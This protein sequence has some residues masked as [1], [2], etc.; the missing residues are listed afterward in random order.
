MALRTLSQL[1]T[2][3]LGLLIAAAVVPASLLGVALRENRRAVTQFGDVNRSGSLRARSLQLYAL[4]SRNQDSRAALVDM[5]AVRESLR[6]RYPEEVARTDTAWA[7][8]AA[9]ESRTGRVDW[10]AAE[11]MRR[12]ADTQTRAIEVQ[13]RQGSAA[14]SRLLRAGLI[15]MVGSL[16]A[17]L[18]LLAGLARAETRRRRLQTTLEDSQALFLAA[19]Q[20]MRDGFAVQDQNGV[21]LMC[22]DGADRLL[23]LAP[24]ELA[25]TPLTSHGWRFCREDGTDFPREEHPTRRALATG[26]VQPEQVV[27]LLRDG[28]PVQWLAICAAPLRHPG[29][30]QPYA[31]VQ[32]FADVTDRKA[33]EI[34][35]RQ[36]EERMRRLHE[37]SMTRDLTVAGRME[38]LLRL[39]CELFNLPAGMLSRAVEDRFEALY[40]VSG[41]NLPAAGDVCGMKDT[42]CAQVLHAERPLARE[43]IGETDWREIPIYAAF[44]LESYIGAPLWV[45]GRAYGTLCFYSTQ[46]RAVP[47]TEADLEFVRLMAQWAGGELTREESREQIESYSIVLEFQ[48][49]ELEKANAELESLAT[50]DGL[51][52]IKNRRAF[53]TRLEEEVA[54]ATRYSLPLSLLL[55][56]VDQFKSYN[57]TF[58]HPAGDEVLKTVAQL[59]D[60]SARETDM[61]ARYGG[62]EFAVLLP[63]TDAAGAW[64]IAERIRQAIARQAWPHRSIT[65]SVGVAHL[66][67]VVDTGSQLIARA[68]E[69]LYQSKA[70]GRNRVSAASGPDYSSPDYSDPDYR[71]MAGSGV[72]SGSLI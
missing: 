72:R 13:A 36:A 5:A 6:R 54:R 37:L 59:L 69:A 52:G 12:A 2:G 67:P 40:A 18:L 17:T 41:E 50:R 22:S 3:F 9:Q 33:A 7:V 14:A 64:V 63:Q 62:E 56:D 39:G 27:G 34:A 20:A 11:A 10:N 26:E 28:E 24:G 25:G 44:G 19:M 16:A 32:T 51:T 30:E 49:Q 1:N 23:H 15:G 29:E 42:Y 53:G 35:V 48:M 66:L 57:D 4:G 68:D 58:G 43:H 70:G 21:V 8:L 60:Q 65:V 38:A 46:P 31:A 47:F 61:A 71:R 55:L 45:S